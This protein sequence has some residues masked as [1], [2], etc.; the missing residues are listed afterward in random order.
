MKTVLAIMAVAIG[1]VIAAPAVGASPD[2][3][4]MSTD[5][6]YQAKL[7]GIPMQDRGKFEGEWIQRVVKMTP[8]ELQKYQI[9]YSPAEIQRMRESYRSP[10]QG[11]GP[12]SPGR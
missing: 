10:Q 3:S 2:Y 1:L 11:G 12:L 4:K 5:Q 6:L 9:D 8:G 7:Q